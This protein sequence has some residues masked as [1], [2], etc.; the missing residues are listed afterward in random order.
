M[1]TATYL[2]IVDRYGDGGNIQRL[3]NPELPF[4]KTIMY[5]LGYEHSFF[6][7]YLAKIAAF[8]NDTKN[9]EAW[10]RYISLGSGK[11]VTSY[12][13][14]ESRAYRDVSGVELTL[15][16]MGTWFSGFVNFT[17][18]LYSSGSFGSYYQK[19]E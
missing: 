8:Y 9:Q 4:S 6:D 14:A 18:Q 2:Y 5:E 11:G 17:Y 1:P 12:R 15:K 3:G 10:T 19:E 13:L 16:K 7:K